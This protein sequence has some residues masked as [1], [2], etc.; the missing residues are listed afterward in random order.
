MIPIF[1]PFFTG[2]EKKYLMDCID[3]TWISSQGKYILKF[4]KVHDLACVPACFDL[5]F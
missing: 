1:E 5:V 3:T 2:N 4:E